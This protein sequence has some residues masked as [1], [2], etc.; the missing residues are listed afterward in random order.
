MKKEIKDEIANPE[1][2]VKNEDNVQETLK[3]EN[4]KTSKTSDKF[5]KGDIVFLK[6][7]K[8]E[9]NKLANRTFGPYEVR[10]YELT[11]GPNVILWNPYVGAES[12]ILQHSEDLYPQKCN[13]ISEKREITPQQELK[14]NYDNKKTIETQ[15][16]RRKMVS[17]KLKIDETAISVL[18]L[19][20]KR[21]SVY[22]S[23]RSV[24]NGWYKGTVIDYEPYIKK[25]WIKY[26]IQDVDG[27]CKYP[28]DLIGNNPGNW[29]FADEK[30][31]TWDDI[32]RAARAARRINVVNTQLSR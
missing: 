26:D 7:Y 3:E 16:E 2:K 32:K 14:V 1:K 9:K 11:D 29:K 22:W 17:K 18:D 28:Q 12:E 13:V 10:G 15:L 30:I 19:I 21:T 4:S 25:H 20:D 23:T 8:S 27:T 6:N 31:Q 5:K 24:P